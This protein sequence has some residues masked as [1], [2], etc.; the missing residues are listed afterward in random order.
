MNPLYLIPL[1]AIPV[2]LKILAP[3]ILPTA[4]FLFAVL[5]AWTAWQVVSWR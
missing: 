2:V 5:L 1:L 4:L 3:G